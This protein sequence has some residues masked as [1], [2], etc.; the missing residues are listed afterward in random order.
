MIKYL[1]TPLII[2][3]IISFILYKYYL[4]IQKSGLIRDMGMTIEFAFIY[5]VI[6]LILFLFNYFSYKYKMSIDGPRGI[7]GDL[8]RKGDQGDDSECDICTRKVAVFKPKPEIVKRKFLI[9]EN[10]IDKSNKPKRTKRRIRR[11]LSKYQTINIPSGSNVIGDKSNM[12]RNEFFKLSNDVSITNNCI[13][14]NIQAPSYINGMAIKEMGDEI[15]QLQYLYSKEEKN[16]NDIIPKTELL[17][18]NGTSGVFGKT[19]IDIKKKNNSSIKVPFERLGDTLDPFVIVIGSS[20]D[21]TKRVDFPYNNYYVDTNPINEQNPY[22]K[23]KFIANIDNGKLIIKKIDNNSG[24][25]QNLIIMISLV[26]KIQVYT[27]WI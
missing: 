4:K 6:N 17:K 25:K 24:W 20:K 22:W 5:M 15:M 7:K 23:D 26:Q 10:N 2:F 27:K 9:D 3:I 11:D 21:N 18:G 1:Y 14:D 12:C 8:G 19:N 16:G 13:D